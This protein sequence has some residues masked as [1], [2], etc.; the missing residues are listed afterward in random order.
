MPIFLAEDEIGFDSTLVGFPTLGGCMAVAMQS[1][2]GLF[3]FHIPPA[4]ESRSP[5]FAEFCS[6]HQ[7]FGEAI[8]L[9]GSCKW[10]AYSLC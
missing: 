5:K 2:H 3:G 1:P 9:Y 7:Q 10:N 8:H 6:G 4:H